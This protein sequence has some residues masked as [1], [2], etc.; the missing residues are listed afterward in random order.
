MKRGFVYLFAHWH[1]TAQA[2]SQAND[3]SYKGFK[4]QILLQY[5]TSQNGFQLGNTRTCKKKRWNEWMKDG[6]GE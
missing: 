2:S 5:Y 3:F 1:P 4:G 6:E